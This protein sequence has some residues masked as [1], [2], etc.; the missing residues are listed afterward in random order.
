[1]K[2]KSSRLRNLAITGFLGLAVLGDPR[3][4]RLEAADKAAVVNVEP[5]AGAVEGENTVNFRFGYFLAAGDWNGNAVGLWS[6][7]E[8]VWNVD[9]FF[10]KLFAYDIGT[11]QRAYLEDFNTLGDANNRSG[12]GLWSDGTTMWVSDEFDDKL[13]AY[14]QETK[15]RLPEFDLD[16]LKEV[17]NES[18]TGMWSD[19]TLMWVVDDGDDKIYVY[20]LATKAHVPSRDIE[21]LSAAG[22]VTP[23]DIWSN[24]TTLWVADTGS[25]TP[26]GGWVAGKVFA[27][28][29]ST[30]ERD[31][32]RDIDYQ[33]LREV[34]NVNPNGL[35]SN[36]HS[37]WISDRSIGRVFVYRMPTFVLPASSPETNYR[38]ASRD[39]RGLAAAGN[40]RPS[41]IWSD[42]TTLWVADNEDDYLYAYDLASGEQ[43]KDK[44][45]DLSGIAGDAA[46]DVAG[47]W[48]NGS[49][50]WVADWHTAQILALD[51]T[52]GDRLPE[53]DLS[54]LFAAGNFHPA[55]LWSDGA[56][57]YVADAED[58]R[59]YAYDLSTGQRLEEKELV[60]LAAV[61][62]A[63]VR[64]L[65]SD[66]VTMWVGDWEDNKLYAYD[67]AER[68][69]DEQH[70]VD[71]LFGAGNLSPA[72]LWSDGFTLWVADHADA[73][74][75]AYEL[76]TAGEQPPV[77]PTP[78][79]GISSIDYDADGQLVIEFSGELKQA[80]SVS[81][82]FSAVEG[83][84]SPYIVSPDQASQFFIA[85]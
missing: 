51:V 60:N 55:G 81:G 38:K 78:P 72:G 77:I 14:S 27:Y 4:E 66:G 80:S 65:W 16:T 52:S 33:S 76:P 61:G 74:I 7:G 36:G 47:L 84:E 48:S 10:S 44:D 58:A 64:G 13:Y 20:D 40:V 29:L 45:L 11:N 26:W 19:G 50:L 9:W 30:G 3:A 69:R 56:T 31:P 79:A 68:R 1:M 71:E 43:Q 5:W 57:M 2:L 24:G 42:G 39:F 46:F 22:N 54:S 70:D 41:S 6:D 73:Q 32:V 83:S 18:P 12:R 17:G 62:N 59:V 85:E 25:W 49:T 8:T 23:R 63:R 21:T 67:L 35:W 37:V 34:G 28:Q 15:E 75:Y 53:G 82:P